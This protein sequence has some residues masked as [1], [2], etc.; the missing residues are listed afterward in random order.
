MSGLYSGRYGHAE[1]LARIRRV[2][3][4]GSSPGLSDL[5]IATLLFARFCPVLS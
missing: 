1:W 3:F 5:R 2:S 4:A